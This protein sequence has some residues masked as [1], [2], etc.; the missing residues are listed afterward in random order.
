MRIAIIGAGICGLYL[1]WRLAREHDVAVFE[2]RGAIGKRACSGLVSERIWDFI[3]KKPELIKNVINSVRVHYPR[4]TVLLRFRPQ[5]L[6]LDRRGLDEHVAELAKDAGAG[7]Y[8]GCELR[9]LITPRRAKP[10]ITIRAGDAE[11]TGEF[12]YIIG[13]DG[14]SSTV[15]RQLGLPEP[16]FRLGIFRY[17]NRKAKSGTA[18][19]WPRADGFGWIIP[20]GDKTELGM[21]GKP[22]LAEQHFWQFCRARRLRPARASAGLIPCGLVQAAKGRVALVGD[23]AGLAKPWS[24]GGIIWGLAAANLLLKNFPN[25]N[26][27]AKAVRKTFAPKILRS[28]LAILAANWAGKH[29]PQLIPANTEIDSDWMF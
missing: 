20:R 22:A 11:R 6:V 21:L 3:P 26:A 24:G 9:Y 14:A 19:V 4:K 18:D 28:R 1:A 25:L 23:A 17:V 15:R 5:M 12:D 2:R 10:Q 29:L 7:L 8:L 13:A 27:Y 16:L